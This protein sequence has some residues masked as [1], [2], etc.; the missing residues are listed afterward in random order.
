M[1]KHFT[2]G[3]PSKYSSV[4]CPTTGTFSIAQREQLLCTKLKDETHME[5]QN[6]PGA[7]SKL[8][9]TVKKLVRHMGMFG[10]VLSKTR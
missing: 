1:L 10:D 9:Q 3:F 6:G 8:S 4:F 2:T 5:A 7:T